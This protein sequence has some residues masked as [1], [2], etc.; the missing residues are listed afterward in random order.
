MLDAC[1]ILYKSSHYSN[2]ESQSKLSL[3]E[4]DLFQGKKPEIKVVKNTYMTAG[5]MVREIIIKKLW[6]IPTIRN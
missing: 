2:M 4:E 3:D 5:A 6:I 1:V